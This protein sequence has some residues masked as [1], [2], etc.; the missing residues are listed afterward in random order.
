MEQLR[1]ESGES[2]RVPGDPFIGFGGGVQAPTF[3]RFNGVEVGTEMLRFGGAGGRDLAD[4]ADATAGGAT[5]IEK[6]HACGGWW[7]V[8]VCGN[9]WG[10]EGGGKRGGD[11]SWEGEVF[12]DETR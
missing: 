8:C 1:R 6:A 3:T 11:A 2:E 10:E 7:V 4:A 5:V 9:G 12:W